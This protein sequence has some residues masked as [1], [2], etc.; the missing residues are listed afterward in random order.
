MENYEAFYSNPMRQISTFNGILIT[1]NNF[2]LP[3]LYIIKKKSKRGLYNLH[4][5]KTAEKHFLNVIRI[6]TAKRKTQLRGIFDFLVCV[7]KRNEMAVED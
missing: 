1:F 5:S 4:N 3:W 2:Q 7:D 6:L